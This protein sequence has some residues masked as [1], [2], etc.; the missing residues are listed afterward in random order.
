MAALTSIK[1]ARPRTRGIVNLVNFPREG[2]LSVTLE[3]DRR[4]GRQIIP[5]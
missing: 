3:R 5:P 4:A 2:I 1:T